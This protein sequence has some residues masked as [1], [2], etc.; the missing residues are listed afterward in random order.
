VWEDEN[1][2]STLANRQRPEVVA[3]ANSILADIDRQRE[4]ELLHGRLPFPWEL[5]EVR[6]LKRGALEGLFTPARAGCKT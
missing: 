2:Y 1:H 3:L 4:R 6:R 5:D